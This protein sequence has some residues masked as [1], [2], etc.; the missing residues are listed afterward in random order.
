MVIPTEVATLDDDTVRAFFDSGSYLERNAVIPVRARIVQELLPDVRGCRVL[1]LGCG[2]GSI[3][4]PL[5]GFGNELTLVDFSPK[6][7]DRARA[8]LPASAAVSF[9]HADVRE[10]VPTGAFDVV[11]CVGLLAHVAP[12]DS[13][14]ARVSQALRLGG[15]AVIQITDDATP[16]GRLLNRYYHR[17]QRS[18]YRLT[19]TRRCDLIAAA[20][21]HG[22]MPLQ[23][24]RYGLL[25][26]G[27]G[28]LPYPWEAGL[29]LAF[30][31]RPRL[32]HLGA[33]L[34]M[35]CS[36]SATNLSST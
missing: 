15:L 6:M 16:L 22:L 7:L 21:R 35:S 4:R 24:R 13:V 11:L 31:R 2:D 27:M 20:R 10:Y 26:P 1:D 5:L 25:M 9:V 23:T 17:R 8:A 12:V 28:R 30:A 18:G 14:I 29:E 33:E 32:K 19:T 36:K 3:S 34:L